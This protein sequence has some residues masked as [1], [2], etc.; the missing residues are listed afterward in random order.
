MG[1]QTKEEKRQ[2]YNALL[3]IE[4]AKHPTRQWIRNFYDEINE[5]PKWSAKQ[6]AQKAL[7]DA[8]QKVD[9]EVG[10]IEFG[11]KIENYIGRID[12]L[13]RKNGY[14]ISKISEEPESDCS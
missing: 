11:H 6:E 3:E 1:T 8:L 10:F 13:L 4:I 9:Q 12:S 2:A 7:I 14:Q 5:T